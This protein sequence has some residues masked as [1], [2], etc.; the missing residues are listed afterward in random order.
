MEYF[1]IPY[2]VSQYLIIKIAYIFPF[3]IGL[4]IIYTYLAMNNN[5]EL[6]NKYYKWNSHYNFLVTTVFKIILYVLIVLILWVI[7][8]P[9]QRP[10]IP[11]CF[12][13]FY[14]YLVIRF[15]IEYHLKRRIIIKNSDKR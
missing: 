9:L 1:W 13:V 3:F 14:F 15:V 12:A 8:E 5:Y 6:K 7:G 10:V 4:D 2:K 11:V